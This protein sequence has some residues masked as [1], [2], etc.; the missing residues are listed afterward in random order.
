MGYSR[1]LCNDNAAAFR[2][3]VSLSTVCFV[4]YSRDLKVQRTVCKVRTNNL[5]NRGFII[6]IR[7]NNRI[8]RQSMGERSKQLPAPPPISFLSP[9]PPFTLLAFAHVVHNCWFPCGQS[10][11]T[12]PTHSP[13]STLYHIIHMRGW[14]L[15]CHFHQGFLLHRYLHRL[16]RS[17]GGTSQIPLVLPSL[18][19]A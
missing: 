7:P 9:S 2:I 11:S 1:D 19:I 14:R 12:Q 16:S 18:C 10:N 5:N 17:E 4:F 15:P 6:N 13:T 8:K 3:S